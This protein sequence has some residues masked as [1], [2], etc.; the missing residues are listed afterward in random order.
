MLVTFNNFFLYLYI[1]VFIFY[2]KIASKQWSKVAV[3]GPSPAPRE[4]HIAV[5][6]N[7]SLIVCG[8]KNDDGIFSDVCIYNTG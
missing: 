8:G 5:C 2:I 7:K 1:I 4:G 3:N 6:Y